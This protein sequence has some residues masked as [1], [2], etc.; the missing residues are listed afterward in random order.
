MAKD[1]EKQK[2][3]TEGRT[4]FDFDNGRA[5]RTTERREGVILKGG[6]KA[7]FQAIRKQGVILEGVKLALTK[8]VVIF[9]RINLLIHYLDDVEHDCSTILFV[10][11]TFFLS[12]NKMKHDEEYRTVQIFYV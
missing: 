1:A 7:C 12:S 5:G 4:S 11:S 3:W 9:K 10:A 2:R 8:D 6:S